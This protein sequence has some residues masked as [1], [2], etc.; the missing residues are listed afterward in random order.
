MAKLNLS[1][2]LLLPSV[3]HDPSET[4]IICWYGAL[5]KKHFLL[6]S[7]YSWKHDFYFYFRILWWI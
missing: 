3:L 4:N 5:V 6:C 7:M 1:V 2:S